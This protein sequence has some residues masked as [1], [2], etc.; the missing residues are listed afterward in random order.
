[1]T[2]RGLRTIALVKQIPGLEHDGTIGADGRLV[3]DP[4]A[5]E[6]NP[7]C[8]RALAQ[9]IRLG[10]HSTAVTM[11]PPQARDVLR[12]ALACGV[13]AAV[14]LSDAALAGSDC[15][16]TARALA[17][18]VTHLGG[19]DLILVGRSS[20][21]GS[22]AAVG[23]MLAEL[24]G[25]PFVGATLDMSVENH[26]LTA[27]LQSEGATGTATVRLPAVV[28]V[29]ERS[30][31]PAKA[32]ADTWPDGD[33]IHPLDT[34]VLPTSQWGEQASPTWVRGVRAAAPGRRPATV[35]DDPA[36]WLTWLA[37]R[38]TRPATEHRIDA[39]P[40]GPVAPKRPDRGV[41]VVTSGTDRSAARVLIAQARRL[42][43]TVDGNVTL[44]S[45]EPLPGAD[46]VVTLAGD[47]PRPTAAA[48]EKWLRGSG[49]PWA[50]LGAATWWDREVL[51]RLAVRLGTGLVSDLT[52]LETVAEPDGDGKR[53][54]L[55]GLKQ[56]GG[57]LVEVLA[58]P[59]TQVATLR[60][61][62][63]PTAPD[64]AGGAWTDTT[65][66]CGGEPDVIRSKPVTDPD[67]GALERAD[68]VI[69]VG[70]G[71][72]PEDYPALE[73]LRTLIGAEFG[74]TRKVT[75]RG[76]L[77][78]SR[79]LGVTAR[80][81]APSVYLAIGMSGNPNH[82]VAVGGAGLIVA[83]NSDRSAAVFGSCDLGIVGDWHEVV[84]LLTEEVERRNHRTAGPR[85]VR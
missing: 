6:M 10:E 74:A 8:R 11:G 25:L 53:H 76:W 48:I 54:R 15:L 22:T 51:S 75:D 18:V 61:G 37:D 28:A 69:G 57:T 4:A 55:V 1:M 79:Q 58:R 7:W 35:T 52:G 16:L 77:P 31:Q 12:E 20:V 3:R 5:G 64:H 21:D 30:C 23:P 50:V 44:L 46:R 13:D 66:L 67:Y 34:S 62:C 32:P 19:A 81:V 39:A 41:V 68:I 43:D 47:E 40:T 82:L 27:V 60:T 59:W 33:A 36:H 85:R 78:H 26:T 38:L 29:A 73:R 84:A 71:V 45:A 80:S 70:Q 14:H 17:D 9:A 24:L 42:A 49:L 56:S 72:A 2:T 65:L 83:V 63:F